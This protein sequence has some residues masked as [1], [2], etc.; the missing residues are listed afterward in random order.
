MSPATAVRRWAGIS[1]SAPA[2]I[3]DD[4][5]I[6]FAELDDRV[7]RSA[8]VLAAGGVRAGDRVAYLGLNSPLFLETLLAAAHLGATFVP[9][10][11]RLAPDEVAYVLG[12]S[13]CHSVVAED[14]YRELID[15]IAGA[16]PVRRFHV[17]GD[18]AGPVPEPPEPAVVDAGDVAVLMYTSGTT[19]RPKG[20]VLTYGNLWWNQANVHATIDIR[21][22]AATLAVA[23]LFHIGGLNAFTLGVL[24]RGGAVVLRRSFDPDACLRDIERYGVASTFM[25]PTMFAALLRS[26]RFAGTDLSSLTAAVVAGAPVPASLVT[27]YADRGVALQQAWGLTETAPF[28]TYLPPHLVRE[29][30][31]SAGFAMPFSEVRVISPETGRPVGAGVAGELCV[32]GPNVTRE[33]WDD[34]RATAAVIDADGWFRTGDLG[35]VDEQGLCYI[36]D[37]LS[38][39]IISGGENISPAEIERV[40]IRFP[41]VRDVAVVGVADP[42][43]GEVPV[44]ALCHAD[45]EPPTLDAVRSFVADHLGRFKRPA[46]L[47]SLPALPRNGSGKIDRSA[48]RARVAA[49][50]PTES[51]IP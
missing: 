42:T 12:H 30:P 2:V 25:V 20:V 41:G 27:D 8:A 39:L 22:R 34:P 21:P 26:E 9:V 14:G 40:L 38:D 51:R 16:V 17:E 18:D 5:T 15:G 13:G 45:A 19:G 28:A 36:V 10:N 50:L 32:R 49:T 1:G 44:A 4:E 47:V 11:F 46:A 33:Y 29:H 6:T 37:R 23:P 43:W 3:Y 24:C 31:A 35:Y 7:R 48:V